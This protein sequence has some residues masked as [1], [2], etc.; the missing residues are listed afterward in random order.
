[1]AVPGTSL[2]HSKD[3]QNRRAEE[4]ANFPSYM[5]GISDGIAERAKV[6]AE[7][8]AA[9]GTFDATPSLPPPVKA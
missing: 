6:V 9:E 2:Q 5:T 7:A 8:G 3:A 1:M 4:K